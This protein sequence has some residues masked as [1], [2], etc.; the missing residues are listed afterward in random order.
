MR[1]V[2]YTGIRKRFNLRADDFLC[3]RAGQA[4]GTDGVDVRLQHL[5]LLPEFLDVRGRRGRGFLPRGVVFG[6]GDKA[7]VDNLV[8]A[9]LTEGLACAELGLI[10]NSFFRACEL[11]RCV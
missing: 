4:G 1:A 9:R 7:F 11:A 3:I 5:D 2:R 8:V 6:G 10:E